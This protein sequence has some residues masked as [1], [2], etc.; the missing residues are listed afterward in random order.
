MTVFPFRP[1]RIETSL[2]TLVQLQE[3]SSGQPLSPKASA[4]IVNF[5]TNGACLIVSQL[6]VDKQHLFYDTL[7]SDSCNLLLR[8]GETDKDSKTFTIG[9]R[10]VW[11]DS[12]D[13]NGKPAFKI[14]VL[15]LKQQKELFT[16]I[17]KG[18][19]S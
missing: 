3:T 14:G 13:F 1:P 6:I 18:A 2:P 4:T 16:L 15:F 19:I 9:A 7:D 12:C 17:K 10:S 5:S 8:T 11:M